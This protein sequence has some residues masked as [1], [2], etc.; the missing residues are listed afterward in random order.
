MKKILIV[1]LLIPFIAEAQRQTEYNRKGDEAMRQMDYQIAKLWYEEG[2]LSCDRY[3]INQLTAIWMADEHMHTSMGPVMNK[4][5]N[6]LSEAATERKD[7]L[8]MQRLIVYY[9]EGIGTVPNESSAAYWKEQLELS[10]NP[11]YGMMGNLDPARRR[12]RMKFFV[13]YHASLAAP[14]GIQLGAM[15]ETW[16][17][18]IRFRT[19]MS[20]DS[21]YQVVCRNGENKTGTIPEFDDNK[22]PYSFLNENGTP[23]QREGDIK[24]RAS[25]LIGTAG[26]MFKAFPDVY[27]SIGGGYARRDVFYRYG[28]KDPIHSENYT[29]FGWAKNTE[30]SLNGVALDLDATVRFADR[31]Y[32]TV[33]C[34]LLNFEKITPGIGI[35][36]IFN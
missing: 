1:L 24:G 29:T 13:G 5:L 3:S 14:Y 28:K 11:F 27:L 12:D 36:F 35:G 7:T 30:V 4:C 31:F 23:A 32:G 17:F 26:F 8:A 16:G 15:N 33:G 34:T 22:V 20:F 6:C 18:Y 9:T 25:A 19:N 10:R 2:V 21:D